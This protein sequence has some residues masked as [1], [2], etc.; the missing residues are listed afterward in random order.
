VNL[1][2]SGGVARVSAW[3]A[4]MG[5]RTAGNDPVEGADPGGTRSTK[6]GNPDKTGKARPEKVRQ[7]VVSGDRNDG[8]DPGRDMEKHP[9]T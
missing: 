8:A 9:K 2:A 7:T 1:P 4:T 3:E 5:K 6:P